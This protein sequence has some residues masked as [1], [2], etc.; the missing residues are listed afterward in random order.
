MTTVIFRDRKQAGRLLADA[1]REF[2]NRPDVTVLALPRGGVPVAYEVARRLKAPLDVF[3]VRRLQA[4]GYEDGGLGALATGGVR[5]LDDELVRQLHITP[6]MIEVITAREQREL[7]RREHLY[8][9]DRP[10]PGVRG[11]TVIVVDD[12]LT[13]GATM[14]VALDALRQQQP[15]RLVAAVPVA[16]PG[17]RD[18]LR[19]RADDVVCAI[20]PEPFGAIG[21]WYRK[22]DQTTDEDVRDLIGRAA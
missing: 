8:R 5:I 6:Q 22:F 11:R 21:A 17:V 9:G 20:A 1:L 14:K 7:E 12:G 16:P 13:T 3:I 2:R 19:H 15:A 18:D 10:A 4:P